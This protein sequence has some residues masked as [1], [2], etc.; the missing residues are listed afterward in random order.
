MVS[1]VVMAFMKFYTLEGWKLGQDLKDDETF[2]RNLRS[3]LEYLA[4]LQTIQP[5]LPPDFQKLLT[6]ASLDD[7]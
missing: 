3:D 7:G 2:A 1:S 6:L 4:Y 5:K